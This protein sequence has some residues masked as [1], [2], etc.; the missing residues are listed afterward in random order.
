MAS[1]VIVWEQNIYGQKKA[2]AH[3]WPGHSSMNIGDMFD[4]PFSPP[5]GDAAAA[6]ATYL[7]SL[8]NTYVSYWPQTQGA[9]FGVADVFGKRDQGRVVRSIADDIKCEGYLPDW[10]I[11]L[12]SSQAQEQN[13]EAEWSGIRTKPNKTYG[14]FKKNCSTIVSR[15]LHAA[16]YN[17][18]KWAVDCNWVWAPGDI[19]RLALAVGGTPMNWVDVV[20]LLTASGI[21]PAKY[22]NKDSTRDTAYGQIGVKSKHYWGNKILTVPH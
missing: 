3:T 11:K 10:V 14:A 19:R 21:T 12:D 5:P 13:M 16:G 17:A 18:K 15:V 9:T 7:G 20:P 1:Y 22:G 4:P 6:H 2:G 8:S